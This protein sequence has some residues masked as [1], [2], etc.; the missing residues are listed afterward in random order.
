MDTLTPREIIAAAD[1]I[2]PLA[3]ELAPMG[4]SSATAAELD[5]IVAAAVAAGWQRP[6]T[7]VSAETVAVAADGARVH[8]LEGRSRSGVAVTGCGIGLTGKVV[9]AAGVA[10]CRACI[11]ADERKLEQQLADEA[12]ARAEAIV[13]AAIE[14]EIAAQLDTDPELEAAFY[15]AAEARL[16]AEV[17]A[18][19][20][21]TLTAERA[22]ADK[23]TRRT[24]LVTQ[25]S[26]TK[27][28]HATAARELYRGTL[29]TMG[30]A[31][32][33]VI[34]R[35]H[36]NTSTAILSALHGLLDPAE[37]IRPYDVT[38]GDARAIT[39]AEIADQLVELGVQRVVALTSNAYAAALEVACELAG[40][41]LVHALAG[42]RGIFE[43]RGRLSR[44]RRSAGISS[45]YA[46]ADLPDLGLV[47]AGPL[48]S[49]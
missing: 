19:F 26:K 34:E 9:V 16:A 29:S 25:C 1:H 3:D 17:E 14:A 41:E 27:L 21:D 11:E 15:A 23:Q 33:D 20:E 6:G 30:I 13:E 37:V 38:W 18:A 35:A 24:L 36:R 42:C 47:T 40:V 7:E 43:Q 2:G 10:G 31:A 28:T 49:R 4:L 44:Y 5:A 22:E 48:A 32:A 46:D 12:V 45:P 8:Y 39:P